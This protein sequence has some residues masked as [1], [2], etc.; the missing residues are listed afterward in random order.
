M[1]KLYKYIYIE[2]PGI[3]QIKILKWQMQSPY[4]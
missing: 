4:L 3:T 1:G 2:E